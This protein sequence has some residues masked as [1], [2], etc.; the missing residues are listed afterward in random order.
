MS[1]RRIAHTIMS[2][3]YDT[4]KQNSVPDVVFAPVALSAR[5]FVG[6]VK[7]LPSHSHCLTTIIPPMRHQYWRS[8]R[9]SY[10]R[11]GGRVVLSCA[12]RARPVAPTTAMVGLVVVVL[13]LDHT[14]VSLASVCGLP[15]AKR[16]RQARGMKRIFPFVISRKL[17]QLSP[18]NKHCERYGVVELSSDPN[19]IVAFRF[20]S[21][22]GTQNSENKLACMARLRCRESKFTILATSSC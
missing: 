6:K 17:K 1:I 19:L 15:Q 9:G 12:P 22:L 2:F 11:A 16:H 3:R 5:R 4:A 14:A 20:P 7:G 8:Q 13:L 21:K 10:G 18:L